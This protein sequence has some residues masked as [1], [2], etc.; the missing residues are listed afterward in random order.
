MTARPDARVCYGVINDIITEWASTGVLDTHPTTST[1]CSLVR[2]SGTLRG[3][4]VCGWR[5]THSEKRKAPRGTPALH[6][7]V[8]HR[9]TW[10]AS[11]RKTSLDPAAA[12]KA[13]RRLWSPDSASPVATMQQL[14]AQ[15]GIRL[16]ALP[17]VNRDPNRNPRH[18]Y[19]AWHVHK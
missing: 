10:V 8:R 2:C 1:L 13:T 16:Q 9:S 19:E 3:S 18:R 17:G 4:A 6:Y 15:M 11:S 12:E 14:G 5:G 7:S